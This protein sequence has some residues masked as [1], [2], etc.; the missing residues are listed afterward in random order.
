MANQ[1][2]KLS[3]KIPLRTMIVIPFV[4]LV[5]LSGSLTRVISLRNGQEAV[6]NVASQLRN[7]IS[8]RI[9]ERVHNYLETAHLVNQLY[10][11]DI[12]L[13]LLNLEVKDNNSQTIEH[14]FGRKFSHLTK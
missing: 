5:A 2:T 12:G 6:D 7:E 13:G 3:S 11:N 14:Y 4:L 9:Q 8:A 1:L 10:A